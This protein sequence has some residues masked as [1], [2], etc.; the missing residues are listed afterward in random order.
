[1]YQLHYSPGSIAMAVAIA[2]EEQQ[3][4][5][6]AVRVDF[7]AGAQTAPDYLALNPKGRVP[8]LVTDHG[9]MTET[10][11]ILEYL[12]AQ[13]G[14]IPAD[15]LA[16][17]QMRTVMYYIASTMHVAHAHKL[18]GAR[19]ADQPSS[20]DDMR[21][22]VTGNMAECCA[23]LAQANP[24]AHFTLGPDLTAAD[25]YVFAALRFAISD[26]VDLATH[27]KLSAFM[28]M[29]HGRASVQAIKDKG[30]LA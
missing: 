3:L 17:T 24:F 10:G 28:T 18:R 13:T 4:P 21:N 5:Y 19:W 25:A 20:F 11:A 12:G 27:P 30:I 9:A 29:M 14:M 26:G 8:A 15:P 7:A 2:L 23:Y 16:A 22:R 1:M 6:K